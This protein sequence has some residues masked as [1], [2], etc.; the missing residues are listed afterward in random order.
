[1]EKRRERNAQQDNNYYDNNKD[2]I[3]K[4][5]LNIKE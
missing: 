1:M 5:F 2:I 4:I 3:L